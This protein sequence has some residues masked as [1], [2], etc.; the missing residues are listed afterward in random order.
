MSLL[1]ALFGQSGPKPNIEELIKNG[2]IV[3]DVRTP[4]EFAGGHF[5]GSKN[6]PLDKIGSK[7]DDIKKMDKPV[8]LCCASGMRSGQ[9]AGVLKRAGLSEV[10][11]AGSWTNL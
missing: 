7:I 4:G 1:S 5:K 10:Y 8:I 6:I 11:N 3:I 9:A 2:A